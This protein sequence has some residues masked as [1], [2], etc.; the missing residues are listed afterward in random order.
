MFNWRNLITR[1]VAGV[2]YVSILLFGV[3][4]NQYSFVVVFGTILVL[5]LD[6][7]YKL[8]EQKTPHLISKLFNILFGVTIFLSAY[9]FLE[10]INILALPITSIIY[11]LFL[12]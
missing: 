7:F 11:L 10:E 3:L 9:L 4:Y 12:F 5:A 8:I 2:V 6:E 1:A